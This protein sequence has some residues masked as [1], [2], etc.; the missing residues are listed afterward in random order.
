MGNE[1]VHAPRASEVNAQ[2]YIYRGGDCEIFRNL[3][4]VRDLF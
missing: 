4:A 3:A 1:A 2:S